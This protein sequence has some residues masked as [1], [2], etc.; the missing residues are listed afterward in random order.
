[1][2][3][4]AGFPFFALK[5]DK[6]G[7]LTPSGTAQSH[8]LR[9]ALA[10]K[11]DLVVISHGWNN[12]ANDAMG[13]YQGLLT[14]FDALGADPGSMVVAGI[15]WPSKFIPD[16]WFAGHPD[17]DAGAGAGD[18]NIA[19]VGGGVSPG[20]DAER[21]QLLA[22]IH[23]FAELLALD[24]AQRN[25]LALAV[26]QLGDND[27]EGQ[28]FAKTV[29]A[30]LPDPDP[31]QQDIEN[32]ALTALRDQATD[33]TLSLAPLIDLKN[34]PPQ[35]GDVEAD[36]GV[37]SMAGGAPQPEETGGAASL[38][39][40]ATGLMAAATRFLNFSTYYLMKE[41]SGTVGLGLNRVL[42]SIREDH[43]DLRIHLVGHSFGAR[44]VTAAVAGAET[45]APSSLSLLQGAFSHNGFATKV[46]NGFFRRVIDDRL[47]AGPIIATHTR[48]DRAVGW[49]YAIASRVSG[50]NASAVGDRNDPY[51]GIGSNGA[52][53]LEEK[54][55]GFLLDIGQDYAGWRDG[56]V[57]NLHSD[58]FIK[59]H[60]D[61]TGTQVA[62][63]LLSAFGVPAKPG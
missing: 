3:T 4:I 38:A 21:V 5:F 50:V 41:R 16:N 30:C 60:S 62:H 11:T 15:F 7:K 40:F 27:S 19:D 43:P 48:N 59:G 13:I 22:E 45:V 26:E 54:T 37:T 10:G 49:A 39:G 36:G 17:V 6:T 55:E 63:A 1:M 35:D 56:G 32:D 9:A 33:E 53:N 25:V 14:H 20:S 18:G 12:D 57:N 28:A 24:E 34:V 61:V 47:V 31:N 51:G 23:A 46:F 44:L 8:E 29:F 2:D 52:Q 42:G 58:T